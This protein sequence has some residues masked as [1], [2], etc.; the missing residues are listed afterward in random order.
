MFPSRIGRINKQ[1]VWRVHQRRFI[2]PEFNKMNVIKELLNV[3]YNFASMSVLDL[4][5]IL[6]SI[7]SLRTD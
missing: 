7:E 6:F 5:D 3:K 4:N 1:F 2:I